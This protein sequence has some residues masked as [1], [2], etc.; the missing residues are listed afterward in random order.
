M[1]TNICALRAEVTTSGYNYC[2]TTQWDGSRLRHERE[3]NEQSL[4]DV[5]HMLGVWPYTV[6]RWE[7]N[8]AE[9]RPKHRSKLESWYPGLLV[10]VEG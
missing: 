6:M 1:T 2:M 8:K 10:P 4:G 3:A 9:P 7:A 5:A